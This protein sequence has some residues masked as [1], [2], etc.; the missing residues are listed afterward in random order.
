MSSGGYAAILFGSLLKVKS[1]LAFIPQTIRRNQNI[2]EKYR[3]ISSYINNTT[4]YFLY[5][6]KSIVNINDAHHI[7]HCERIAHHS[8]VYLT[9][10]EKLNLKKMRDNGELYDIV[11]KI[12]NSEIMKKKISIQMQWLK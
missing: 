5:G 3:D 11:S 1:V 10:K 2:D 4:N 9:K 8:N 12:V 7:Y 6:D